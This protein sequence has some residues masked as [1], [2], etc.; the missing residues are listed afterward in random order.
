M[1]R[2]SLLFVLGTGLCAFL[3]SGCATKAETAAASL[4]AIEKAMLTD[5]D[6]FYH[7]NFEKYPQ[8]R[9]TL[10]VG[11]FDS[12]TGGLTILNALL[13][14]DDFNNETGALGGDGVPDFS[15]E[16]FIY[17]ADQANM[18]YGNYYSQNKSGLLIEH[19]LKDGQFLLSDKYYQHNRSA[20][21]KADKE[22]VK[23]IVVACN[24]ATAYGKEH[25]E[26]FVQRSGANIRIIG[27]IDAGARGAL[28]VFAKEESGSIGVLATV[29][30]IASKGYK[31]TLLDLKDELGYTGNIMIFNRGGYGLAEAVDEEKEFI[32]RKAGAPRANYKG[33][34]WQHPDYNIDKALLDVYNFNFSQNQIL[35][36]SK[37]PGE[38]EILQLNAA[39]NYVRYHLVSLMEQMRKAPGAQPLKALLLGCTHYPYL[40]KE[41]RTVLGE[42]YNYRKDGAY[43]YRHLMTDSIKLID[44]AV[45]VA[46]ELYTLMKGQ[47]LFNAAGSADSSEF[48][49]SMP[50]LTNPNVITDSLG[51]FTYEYKYGRNEGEV[52]EY[53]KM[54]PFSRQNIPQETLERLSKMIPETYSRITLF[55]HH[56]PKTS[57]LLP[58]ERIGTTEGQ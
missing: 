53:V 56:N 45:N 36:D 57:F 7:I 9:K 13:A 26:S 14:F 8:A 6:N 30:T 38:C 54:V 20:S 18:P 58:Q 43:V 27:V 32:D 51:R 52:Q 12:G 35:C 22:P 34:S 44:P 24:T 46:K 49:I 4:S 37:N 15:K 11:V 28:E 21:F 39:E 29:G 10:P 17:L 3:F 2:I 31:R 41:I 1:I 5:K 25:L 42:L 55:N 33:P 23:V 40:T 48:Y 50:N 19:I 16:K 47:D